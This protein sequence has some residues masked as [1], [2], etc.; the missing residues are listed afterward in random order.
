MSLVELARFD[1]RVEADLA[2]LN[3]EAEGID[4]VLFDTDMHGF[5]W[6]PIMPIRLMVLEEDLADARRLLP[7]L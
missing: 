6:G 5:G 1:N 3:L 4:A 7:T 2:R